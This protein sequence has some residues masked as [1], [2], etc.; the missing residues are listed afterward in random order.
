MICG[1][2]C[3]EAGR[4]SIWV[5]KRTISNALAFLLL[6]GC[7]F[8]PHAHLLTPTEPRA[9]DIPGVYVLDRSYL[10]KSVEGNPPEMEIELRA[11]GTFK[12]TNVPPWAA[13]EPGTNFFT[14]FQSGTGKWIK[15]PMGT[16][17]RSRLIWGVYLQTPDDRLDA[18]Q[19][20]GDAP[21]Y[22]LMFTFGDPDSGH[23]LL[24]K[25]R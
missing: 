1:R 4:A 11:D 18:P 6:A 15:S 8:S 2:L 21:P 22:G 13:G 17:N 12:A 10:P 7:Q 14:T 5:M 23:A 20:I 3:R 24:L 16:T 25:R 9:E 19:F